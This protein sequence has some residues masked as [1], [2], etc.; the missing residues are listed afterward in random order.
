MQIRALHTQILSGASHVSMPALQGQAN[1]FS[2][3]E[4]FALPQGL[5]K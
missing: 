4:M 3:E 2:L 5:S 1:E